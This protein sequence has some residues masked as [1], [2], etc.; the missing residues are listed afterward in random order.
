MQGKSFANAQMEWLKR[1]MVTHTRKC[2]FFFLSPIVNRFFYMYFNARYACSCNSTQ[3]NNSWSH[4]CFELPCCVQCSKMSMNLFNLAIY[5]KQN[6]ILT[7]HTGSRLPATDLSLPWLFCLFSLSFFFF[8]HPSISLLVCPINLTA[9]VV[10]LFNT[11][12][13]SLVFCC[14]TSL[15]NFSF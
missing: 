15:W 3:L 8:S 10:F 6:E 2:E 9:T 12:R 14:W 7:N 13:S 5:G 4:R 11:E 1:E